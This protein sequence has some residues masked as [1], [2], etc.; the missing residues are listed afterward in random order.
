VNIALI[1]ISAI[2]LV[3]LIGLGFFIRASVK[4]R[5]EQLSF[6]LAEP[7]ETFL[8]KLQSHLTG[9]AYRLVTVSEDAG[10]IYEGL[11]RPSGFMAIFLTSLAVG[12]LACLGLMMSYWW[13]AV[14]NWSLALIVLAP[15]AGVFYWKKAAR[16]EQVNLKLANSDSHTIV[17]VTGHRDELSVLEKTLAIEPLT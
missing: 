8:P 1:S 13:P 10:V 4:E 14:G 16:P 9:R 6:A 11:V 3:M 17:T 7:A 5:R 2:A 12:G 15:G